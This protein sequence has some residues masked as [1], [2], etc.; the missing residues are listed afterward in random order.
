[1]KASHV[2]SRSQ[3]GLHL[4]LDPPCMNSGSGEKNAVC[5]MLFIRWN[6]TL[7]ILAVTSPRA[8]KTA[9][10]EA[11]AELDWNWIQGAREGQEVDLRA[12]R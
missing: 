4:E 2:I 9:G 7:E 10:G 3:A 8:G 12:N 1:M 11:V 5:V 6:L